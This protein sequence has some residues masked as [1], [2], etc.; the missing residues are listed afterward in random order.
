MSYI[1]TIFDP[2]FML[3]TNWKQRRDI[4]ATGDEIDAVRDGAST[5][6]AILQQQIHDLSLTVMALVEIL[7]ED[8]KFTSEDLRARVTAAVIGEKHVARQNADPAQSAW[9]ELKK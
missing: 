3:D 4:I 5:H 6:F 2:R 1:D 8:G 9:D 7:V